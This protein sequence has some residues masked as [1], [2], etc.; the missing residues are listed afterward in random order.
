M[1]KL[2]L[3]VLC[4]AL[5]ACSC[6]PKPQPEPEPEP[7]PEPTPE[8]VTPGPGDYF[9]VLPQNSV[10]S[11]WEAGDKIMVQGNYSPAAITVTL[12]AADIQADGRTA[13]VHLDKVPDTFHEPD[14]LYA[15]Y[16][17][18]LLD[19]DVNMFCDD[20]FNFTETNRQL[21]CAWLGD[22]NT[23]SFMDICAA[24]TFSVDG[25]WDGCTL[26]GPGWEMV[27]YTGRYTVAVNSQTQNWRQS[28]EPMDYFL[29]SD[30]SGGKV[31]IFFPGGISLPNGFVVYFKKG[32]EY[33][34]SY[35]YS[36][37]VNLNH[38]G[39]LELG[40]ITASLQDYSGPKPESPEMPVLKG[41]TKYT[42][43]VTEI[44]GICLTADG[45]ALWAVGDNGYLGQVSF[46]GQTTKFWSCKK[47][48]E[49]DMEG[50]TIDP[51]TGDLY[52]ALE[53]GAHSQSVARISAPDYT[54]ESMTILFKVAQAANYDN[55]GLEGITYYKDDMVYVG[56][57]VDANLFLYKLN[58]EQVGQT[59]SLRKITKNAILEVGGLYYDAE[60]DWLWVTDSET[61]KLYVLDG[62]I[63]H[64]LASYS[65]QYCSNNE[66]ICVDRAHGCVWVANDDD[67]PRLFRLEF[68]GL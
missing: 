62:E 32:N 38:D 37:A 44:S 51:V 33:P 54:K 60:K 28:F 55:S 52:I 56:S 45:S 5:V 58:G 13:K 29:A 21:M 22:N 30:I 15:A 3:F 19:M 35:T 34:K 18:D 53:D 7:T 25:D 66:G 46:D 8:V 47:G 48:E 49:E 64:I 6:E 67:T 40:N 31:S 10:K 27:S 43:S 9:F 20:L 42:V 1:K 17:A 14:Y 11:A 50:A 57:Q 68:E 12:A 41:Y 39:V 36:N 26:A 2:Q 61:H 4:L 16:P 59:K 24:V 23:F 63:T 65:V